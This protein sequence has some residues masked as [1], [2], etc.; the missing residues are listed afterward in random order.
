METPRLGS[1]VDHC[2]LLPDPRRDRTTRH[3]LL[4]MVVMAVCAVMCGADTWVA[5]AAYGRAT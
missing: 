2:A 4:A 5:L 3:L 1:L